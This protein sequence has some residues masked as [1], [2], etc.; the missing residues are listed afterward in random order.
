MIPTKKFR[1]VASVIIMVIAALVGF[2][3]GSVLS[4]GLHGAILF[5]LISGIGCIVY[6]VDNPET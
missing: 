5:A 4:D 3:A 1:T 2:F 6:T